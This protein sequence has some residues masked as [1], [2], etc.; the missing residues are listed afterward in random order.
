MYQVY[1]W[2]Y[3][4]MWLERLKQIIVMLCY[5]M[6]LLISSTSLNTIQKQM[7]QQ[8][9]IIIQFMERYFTYFKCKGIVVYKYVCKFDNSKTILPFLPFESM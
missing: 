3:P 1:F 4:N 9:I 8:L 5:V 2:H 7:S 6:L